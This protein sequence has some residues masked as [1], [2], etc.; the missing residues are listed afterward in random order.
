MQHEIMHEEVI[1][2]LTVNQEIELVSAAE[3]K[4][5]GYCGHGQ[6]KNRLHSS[7][8]LELGYDCDHKSR[9]FWFFISFNRALPDFFV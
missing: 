6:L 5:C 9:I 1:V 4:Q 2:R 8:A 7:I 3:E